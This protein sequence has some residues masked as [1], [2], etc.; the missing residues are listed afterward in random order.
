MRLVHNPGLITRTLLQLVDDYLGEPKPLPH[1]TE[2]IYCLTKGYWDRT[3]P[4]LPGEREI[5]LFALGFGLEKLLL[6]HTKHIKPG[7]C[8][9][10]Y[11]SPD[12]LAFTD[13]PGELKTTRM[14]TK[15][16]QQEG[17]PITWERQ[18]LGYL[19][20]LGR[21]DYE[22][23]IF[24]ILGNYKP[25]FPEL[26]AYRIEATESEIEGNWAWLLVRRSIYLACIEEKQVPPP[27]YF[28]EE[29]ECKEC[30]YSIRCEVERRKYD[31]IDSR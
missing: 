14:A 20:C 1:L 29:W 12:F 22:L 19:H 17:L 13:I 15:K 21:T 18:I 24:H 28:C 10:I 5:L 31:S 7:C 11:Y 16:V 25:P 30:R 6:K 23:I 9:G 2:L 8:D 4:V 27:R 3:D 26:Q